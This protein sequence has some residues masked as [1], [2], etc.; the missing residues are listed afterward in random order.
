M[1]NEKQ[2]VKVEG[3]FFLEGMYIESEV[4]LVTAGKRILLCKN[5]IITREIL[6]RLESFEEYNGILYVELSNVS[7]ILEQYE[8]FSNN[9]NYVQKDYT[10]L[11]SSVKDSFDTVF[12]TG[13]INLKDSEKTIEKVQQMVEIVDPSLI[14]QCASY[15]RDVSEYLYAHSLNVS[16]INGLMAKWLSLGE[17]NREKLVTIG[18]LHDMGKVKIPSVILD[19]P[20]KLTREEFTII[21][22]HPVY[23]W[24]LIKE[25]GIDDE[26]ILAA[27]RGHH[28]KMNGSGYPDGLHGDEIS[29]FSRITAIADIYDAMVAKRV[30][31]EPVSPFDVLDSFAK[32]KYSDLDIALVNLFINKMAM[33]L[34]GKKV[35][36]NNGKI[37]VVRYVD[38]NRFDAAIVEVNG[39]MIELGTKIKCVSICQ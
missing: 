38:P 12:E 6:K 13:K 35:L 4:Y 18:L 8:Y 5:T 14:L 11:R 29:L 39:T 20:G 33:E 21:K 9:V 10:N 24:E 28:E 7:S 27:I 31:K 25:T 15:M 26:D 19:K 32:D 37:A 17:V 36:L 16:M 1:K 34:V 3:S 30:Y 22:L 23:S 2:Y